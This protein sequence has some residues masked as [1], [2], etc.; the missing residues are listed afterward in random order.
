MVENQLVDNRGLELKCR[1]YESPHVFSLAKFGKEV[2]NNMAKTDVNLIKKPYKM[3]NWDEHQIAE[4]VKCMDPETGPMHFMSNYFFIQHPTRGKTQY[5]PYDYQL[6]LLHTYH[7]YRFSIALLPRQTGKSTT[8][9]GYLLWYGMFVPD[10]TIL[11]AAHKYLGAQEIMQRIR[12]AY[13]STPDFIRAGVVNYNKGSIEF[14][15]GSRIVAQTTTETTGRGMSITCLSTK[16]TIVTVRDKIT[17]EISQKT[18]S[19]LIQQR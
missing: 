8:A 6:R 10:S 3:Q 11:I 13:E 1:S 5:Q 18:I 16:N 17:G 12:Y 15:N 4:L 9:A 14:E 7:N 2:N 19:E